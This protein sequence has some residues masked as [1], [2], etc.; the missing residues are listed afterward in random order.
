MKRL[1]QNGGVLEPSQDRPLFSKGC[2][3]GT[4]PSGGN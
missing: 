1:R 2:K 3:L 4:K